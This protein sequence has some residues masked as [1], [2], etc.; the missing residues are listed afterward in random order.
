MNKL[1]YFNKYNEFIVQIDSKCDDNHKSLLSFLLD[2]LKS[3]GID[4]SNTFFHS[5]I[6]DRE[7]NIIVIRMNNTVKHTSLMT[8][9]NNVSRYNFDKIYILDNNTDLSHIKYMLEKQTL[10]PSYKPRTLVYE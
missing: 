10:K 3:N 7:S 4:Y 9:S 6:T 8:I 2:Y 1:K 5:F